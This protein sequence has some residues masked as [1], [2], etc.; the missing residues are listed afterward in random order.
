MK[1]L[2]TVFIDSLKPESIEYMPFL[3]SFEVRRRV[4]TEL[5]YSLTCH[6]SIYSGVHPDK[7]KVWVLWKYSPHSSPFKWISK[8]KIDRLPHNKYSKFAC[9]AVTK[10]LYRGKTLFGMP[11]RFITFWGLWHTPLKYWS[12][13][14]T[15]E[16]QQTLFD[17]LQDNNIGFEVVYD[18]AEKHKFSNLKPWTYIFIGDIDPLTHRYGQDSIPTRKRLAEIDEILQGIYGL[19]EKEFG[20]FYFMCF[21]DHGQSRVKGKVDLYALFESHGKRFDDYIRFMDS[22]FV[23]FW[24]RNE[25]EEGEV[26]EILSELEGKGFILTEEHLRKYKISMPDNRYGDLIFYLNVP[27][28]F[29]HG[30]L[31]VMGKQFSVSAV[32]MHGYL[33]DHSESDG[34]FISNKQ[35]LDGSHVELVDIMPSILDALNIKLPDYVDGKV[36]WK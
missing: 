7:H 10:L 34:I 35:V 3:N 20:D 4:K 8:L 15:T 32:E 25:K 6:S 18:V 5:G 17:I 28:I 11:F 24:F 9:F 26:R 12:Y 22:T 21:S 13:L 27:H 1:P 33:P 16:Y 30:N 2:L 23:R 29:D 31:K 19:F 14:D 36:L